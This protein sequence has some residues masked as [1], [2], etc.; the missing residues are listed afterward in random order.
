M[1]EGAKHTIPLQDIVRE[2]LAEKVESF[3]PVKPP[4]PHF[5][6]EIAA[7]RNRQAARSQL[8]DAARKRVAERKD[9]K[10]SHTANMD[11]FTGDTIN[12]SHLREEKRRAALIVDRANYLEHVEDTSKDL[13][14][15]KKE[16][17]FH[18]YLA[19]NIYSQTIILTNPGPTSRRYNILPPNAP[20]T[21][22]TLAGELKP[23]L[24]KTIEI[25]FRPRSCADA[26][27]V[28]TVRGKNFQ[29]LIP[30]K[31][32]NEKANF[33]LLDCCL[34]NNET[35][36][37]SSIK[38]ENIKTPYS[39]VKHKKVFNIELGPMMCHHVQNHSLN[40]RIQHKATIPWE[41][42]ERTHKLPIQ[43]Y[44]KENPQEIPILHSIHITDVSIH[45]SSGE[46]KMDIDFNKES[47]EG[48]YFPE[49]IPLSSVRTKPGKDRHARL[50][51]AMALAESVGLVD[52]TGVGIHLRTSLRREICADTSDQNAASSLSLFT[53]D[54]ASYIC[55]VD[56]GGIISLELNFGD[57]IQATD[58]HTILIL[59]EEGSSLEIRLHGYI[60]TGFIEICTV[61][62]TQLTTRPRCL[63]NISQFLSENYTLLPDQLLNIKINSH[64]NELQKIP[65]HINI[66][67]L[68][69]R[70]L[71]VSL[72]QYTNELARGIVP[73]NRFLDNPRAIHPCEYTSY[74]Q[75]DPANSTNKL[76]TP[77]KH[78]HSQKSTSSSHQSSI[79]S[80]HDIRTLAD[81]PTEDNG[82]IDSYMKILNL[83]SQ[84]P[85]GTLAPQRCILEFSYCLPGV[86][87]PMLRILLTVVPVRRSSASINMLE[88]ALAEQQR[89][90][91]VTCLKSEKRT[92]YIFIS[93]PSIDFG[94][95]AVSE[96]A[97][98]CF[99]VRNC[100]K[101]VFFPFI[102]SIN[103][104][105]HAV[106]ITAGQTPGGIN[107]VLHDNTIEGKSRKIS[108]TVEFPDVIEMLD[109]S[110]RTSAIEKLK[111]VITT[112]GMELKGDDDAY[113]DDPS[114]FKQA[115]PGNVKEFLKHNK[116]FV[117]TT[118]PAI[119]TVQGS[120]KPPKEMKISKC[121]ANSCLVTTSGSGL[122]SSGRNSVSY[123]TTLPN[124]GENNS[125][126][127]E[128]ETLKARI[129]KNNGNIT[130]LNDVLSIYPSCGIL[131]P[132]TQVQINVELC[133]LSIGPIEAFLVINTPSSQYYTNVIRRIQAHLKE[134]EMRMS[135]YQSGLDKA[136][137]ERIYD[138]RCRV[139]VPELELM[140][141]REK[142]N[143]TRLY[144]ASD[145]PLDGI[146]GHN[147]SAASLHLK[148]HKS[149]KSLT[150]T[151]SLD[152]EQP[153]WHESANESPF[154]DIKDEFSAENPEGIMSNDRD[155]CCRVF[156]VVAA[157]SVAFLEESI[158]PTMDSVKSVTAHIKN[159]GL[160]EITVNLTVLKGD[161]MLIQ[162]ITDEQR[163]TLTPNSLMALVNST[164]LRKDITITL[165]VNE[166]IPID[167]MPGAENDSYIIARKELSSFGALAYKISKDQLD[168]S[169]NVMLSA[170]LIK[171]R[172]ESPRPHIYLV[173][174]PKNKYIISDPKIP[175][176]PE[177]FLDTKPY[178]PVV[179]E[180]VIA[181][182]SGNPFTAELTTGP[183]LVAPSTIKVPPKS[184]AFAAFAI[185]PD[186][187]GQMSTFI[188]FHDCPVRI[189][190]NAIGP[191]IVISSPYIKNANLLVDHQ[192]MADDVLPVN[193]PLD[194]SKNISTTHRYQKKSSKWDEILSILP[195][196]IIN[197]P[198]T[199]NELTNIV[200]DH[201]DTRQLDD[202]CNEIEGNS[203]DPV[204]PQIEPS[205]SNAPSSSKPVNSHQEDLAPVGSD[206]NPIYRM[207]I[208][209]AGQL[210]R[211]LQNYLDILDDRKYRA[212]ISQTVTFNRRECNKRPLD[213]SHMLTSRERFLEIRQYLPYI[214]FGKTVG[215]TTSRICINIF[216][217]TV[218]D[219]DIDIIVYDIPNSFIGLSAAWDASGHIYLHPSG[220]FVSESVEHKPDFGRLGPEFDI[221]LLQN[222]QDTEQT[223]VNNL[224]AS[225]VDSTTRRHFLAQPLQKGDD[226]GKGINKY[227][228]ATPEH[229]VLGSQKSTSVYIETMNFDAFQEFEA[230]LS[231]KGLFLLL[232]CQRVQPQISL[233]D[234]IELINITASYE[235]DTDLLLNIANPTDDCVYK[236]LLDVPT[237][238]ELVQKELAVT[239]TLLRPRGLLNFKLRLPASKCLEIAQS[240]WAKEVVK[241]FDTTIMIMNLLKQE[242]SKY[243]FDSTLTVVF[244]ECLDMDGTP[245]NIVFPIACRIDVPAITPEFTSVVFQPAFVGEYSTKY[246]KIEN[247]THLPVSWEIINVP[248][249]D[250]QKVAN[251]ALRQL[252]SM[253]HLENL[254]ELKERYSINK[255]SDI[256]A[257]LQSVNSTFT[258]KHYPSLFY[259]GLTN[260]IMVDDPS[261]FRFDYLNGV[262]EGH[263]NTRPYKN[264]TIIAKFT[265]IDN[266]KNCA[267]HATKSGEKKI[268]FFSVF[269]I[270]VHNGSGGWIFMTGEVT[271]DIFQI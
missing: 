77:H 97:R 196:R 237:P 16:I 261:V 118:V 147:R 255:L 201:V 75:T 251:L 35:P 189:T 161:A 238:F 125:S 8:I 173:N 257:I 136:A 232:K 96:T 263:N 51:T 143:H 132:R 155:V 28:L 119:K 64:T 19:G 171:A 256:K 87:A 206:K 111:P 106:S 37:I 163:A 164:L 224:S 146:L 152:E 65:I 198:L 184:K 112:A 68:P 4:P 71:Q 120:Q 217:P 219:I 103:L 170:V 1:E 168:F 55:R 5:L 27:G 214:S 129:L 197:V 89:I 70:L 56:P 122:N 179:V 80:L 108:E 157:P 212:I 83:Y 235:R 239:P 22:A 2:A 222:E 54:R 266:T 154:A 48:C 57:T 121:L 241:S 270:R 88:T 72:L 234:G 124:E 41:E 40:I 52:P 187:S 3:T 186:R 243:L 32:E 176:S 193:G 253:H 113:D 230:L 43:S 115:L 228:K 262:I 248:L 260:T 205:D 156:G 246:I 100:S 46:C 165:G 31:A 29:A 215:E 158:E 247:P 17:E 74:S 174:D 229:V 42:Y 180:F 10:R 21:C 61:G 265:P 101:T 98:F 190:L 245:Y 95:V 185:L 110:K 128:P 204:S 175:L 199:Y 47:C 250:A 226:K 259:D 183:D 182:P 225:T 244:P 79:F 60:K 13:Q 104:K 69:D 78:S 91:S 105:S 145:K 194:L 177:I 160:T 84:C 188:N 149:L 221:A 18:N 45:N 236:L 38:I 90:N 209:D 82:Q 271:E 231:I 202:E 62:T 267:L 135:T 86:Y 223:T 30:I 50:E 14:L 49:D 66:S 162:P 114:Q 59:T 134:Q 23:G 36:D 53:K 7:G 44:C 93:K 63:I 76:G 9:S 130:G 142:L 258:E 144:C 148:S 24:S 6:N 11:Y 249:K 127:L 207:T 242:R 181:N 137:L 133:P 153:L 159:T 203:K 102:V 58:M 268:K 25:L 192:G 178:K 67:S 216:N 15:S 264:M 220:P 227:F 208:E 141:Y 116:V 252:P 269:Y 107:F 169:D 254:Y 20:F 123:G 39:A 167:V 240:Q 117:P 131:P 151:S 139:T 12:L 99:R 81:I 126:V 195:N 73:I 166:I 26:H 34:D 218:T 94:L 200:S 211:P 138:D 33:V 140:R 210:V 213:F 191:D 172:V 109:N 150:D 233:S 85:K 92:D